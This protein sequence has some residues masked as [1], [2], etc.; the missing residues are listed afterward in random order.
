MP[1]TLVLII[2]VIYVIR[3]R[4]IVDSQKDKKSISQKGNQQLQKL[5]SA[6]LSEGDPV[7]ENL[8]MILAKQDQFLPNLESIT[9]IIPE[10]QMVESAK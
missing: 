10:G 8:P 1:V 6:T 7:M 5:P 9:I 4:K 3:K 2:T